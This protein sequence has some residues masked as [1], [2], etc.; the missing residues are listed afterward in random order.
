M[1]ANRTYSIKP[2][3]KNW[4]RRFR[5]QEKLLKKILGANVVEI[6]HVG[7]TSIPGMDAK[8]VIDV[9]VVVKNLKSIDQAEKKFK[10]LGYSLLIDHVTPNSRLLYKFRGKEKLCNIHLLPQSNPESK[11]LLHIKNY[12]IAHPDVARQ[13]VQ[14]KKKLYKKTKDY[15]SY[16]KGKNRFCKALS[17]AA[18]RWAK[19]INT[20]QI[21]L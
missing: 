20:N 15:A 11:R 3:S 10:T 6:H 13:Y 17:E 1:Q 5:A 19:K 4:A 12:L 9:L 21:N 8:P 2:Y 18:S 16:R 14:L 7:S